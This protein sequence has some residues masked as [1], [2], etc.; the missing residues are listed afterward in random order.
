MTRLCLNTL[1]A[2][3][4]VAAVRH[5]RRL[6]AAL[7]ERFAVTAPTARRALRRLVALQWLVNEGTARAPRY[8][9]GCLRQVVQRYALQGLTEDLPW[10]RDFAPF[11]ALP[12][13]VQQMA[14]HTFYE[15]VNNAIDHSGGTAVTVSMR[16]TA[17]HVQLLVSDDGV[18]LFGRI[19]Q[20][21]AIEEPPL[22][23][24]ELS[25]GKLTSQPH[26]HTG[27]GLFFASRLADVFEL[28]AND[29]SFQHRSWDA[30][31]WQAQRALKHRGTSAYASFLLDT[32]R[33]VE[34]VRQVYSLDGSGAAFDRT[35]VGLQLLTSDTVGLQSRAQARRVSARCSDFRQV[36]LDFA[37]V[38][39][40]SHAF[41]DELFR[42]LSHKET[43]VRWVALNMSPTVA[44]LIDGVSARH[45]SDVLAGRTP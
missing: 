9:P 5:P 42:V 19:A 37:G 13:S 18:G 40:V 12:G 29:A 41:A 24:L 4:T 17:S 2:W 23:M 22:A 38:P 3:I 25:K 43:G 21:F 20:A 7:A 36:E 11:F 30:R 34:S 26:A 14:E 35:R 32:D 44:R 45:A 15:L 28:H 27:H 16:Q 10:R 31:G 1:T 33:T 6:G 8:A 39:E